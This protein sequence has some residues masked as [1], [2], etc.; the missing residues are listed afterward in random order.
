MGTFGN[1][2]IEE[3]I[4]RGG[5]AE[6]YRARIASGPRQGLAVAIKRLSPDKNEDPRI[7][8]L[9]V[10]EAELS[11]ALHHPNIT[12]VYESGQI[13]GIAYL[14]MELVEGKD[15]SEIIKR[16]RERDIQLPADFCCFLA[17][18][19]ARGLHY[20]HSAGEPDGAPLGI[21][22][23]DVNPSNVFVSRTGEVKVGDFGVARAGGSGKVHPID[24]DLTQRPVQ[25]VGPGKYRRAVF[26]QDSLHYRSRLQFEAAVETATEPR[27]PSG[28]LVSAA[29]GEKLRG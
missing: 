24:Q 17:S 1:Y 14:V 23:C 18:E 28:L 3:L 6:V 27:R 2:Q 9:F 8:A 21:V 15:L 5:M 4:G 16:C 20:A 13:D 19:V 29:E 12:E 22:H 11:R 26:E 25:Q 10:S 7:A